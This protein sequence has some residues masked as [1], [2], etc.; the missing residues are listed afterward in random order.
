V[1]TRVTIHVTMTIKLKMTSQFTVIVTNE[2]TSSVGVK[3]T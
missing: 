2:F 1:T 3:M